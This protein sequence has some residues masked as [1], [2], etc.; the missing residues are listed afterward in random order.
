MD[1]EI[2]FLGSD[3]EQTEGKYK[4]TVLYMF[5]VSDGVLPKT[6]A[7]VMLTDGGV[8]IIEQ[9]GQDPKTAARI[10]LQRLL[11]AGRNPYDSQIFLRVPHGHAEYF[12]KNG[13][14]DSLPVL[15][16]D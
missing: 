13:N 15:T 16:D 2:E 7:E 14:F 1:Y 9:G 10:A 8:D 3:R 6:H 4:A 12:S 5:S 11:R